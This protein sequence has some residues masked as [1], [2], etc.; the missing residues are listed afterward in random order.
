M[1]YKIPGWLL[2]PNPWVVQGFTTA[3]HCRHSDN[4]EWVTQLG[5]KKND[6]EHKATEKKG[7]GASCVVRKERK[8]TKLLVIVSEKK[9]RKE[10]NS[11]VSVDKKDVC[12]FNERN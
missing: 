2:L 4:N 5:R 3:R 12:V 9:T 1:Q 6:K 11:C 8:N 7:Q 10:K